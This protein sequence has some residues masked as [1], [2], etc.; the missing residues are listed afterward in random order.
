MA[1]PSAQYSSE[2]QTPMNL[3]PIDVNF[4]LG[5]PID[6]VTYTVPELSYILIPRIAI[7]VM[8]LVGIGGTCAIIILY[9]TKGITLY[10]IIGTLGLSIF[11]SIFGITF[12]NLSTIDI[13]N[14]SG[15]VALNKAKSFFCL[16]K[17]VKI[18]ISEIAQVVLQS[19]PPDE[20]NDKPSFEVIFKLSN[21]E[22]VR[23]WL[24]TIGKNDEG[25]KCFNIIRKGLPSRITFSGNLVY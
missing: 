6:K 7:S 10:P 19:H 3:T 17:T 18:Q 12:I 11:S 13:D 22:E 25:K 21:G 23:E 8:F 20:D 4:N 15:T 16:K 9:F 24:G 2:I 5:E 1:E 14:T